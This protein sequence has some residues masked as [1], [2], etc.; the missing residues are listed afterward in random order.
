MAFSSPPPPPYTPHR[1]SETEPLISDIRGHGRRKAWPQS[2]WICVWFLVFIAGAFAAGNVAQ[3]FRVQALSDRLSQYPP[4]E[5]ELQAM[6]KRYEKVQQALE[7][8]LAVHARL[9]DYDKWAEDR[10]AHAREREWWL[11]AREQY[12]VDRE[13][14]EQLKTAHED[15]ASAWQKALQEHQA[16]QKRWVDEEQ[17]WERERRDFQLEREKWAAE[18]RA[19]EDRYRREAGSTLGVF[20]EHIDSHHCV[21]RGT[22]EYTAVVGF[23]ADSACQH[24]PITVNGAMFASPQEC[25]RVSDRAPPAQRIDDLCDAG[26]GRGYKSLEY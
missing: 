19:Q 7:T 10:L 20:W 2:A 9:Q 5:A 18:R 25:R 21:G 24:M 22:R 8:D 23:D 17:G 11:T 26:W 6:K 13:E 12:R 1:Q 16:A 15:D 3:L 4:S 14:W